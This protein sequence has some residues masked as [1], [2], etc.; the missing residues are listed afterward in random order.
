MTI[1]LS[2]KF[3]FPK[4]QL[5]LLTDTVI[6]DIDK[7][8]K[9]IGADS[10]NGFAI[11]SGNQQIGFASDI[12][13]KI[14]RERTARQPKNKEFLPESDK[15]LQSEI[16]KFAAD[17]AEK[18]YTEDFVI[19]S[20]LSGA[21][22]TFIKSN[23]SKIHHALSVEVQYIDRDKAIKVLEPKYSYIKT[24]PTYTNPRPSIFVRPLSIWDYFEVIKLLDVE[25]LRRL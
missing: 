8:T 18:Y 10:H 19:I 2:R 16:N 14:V 25:E 1:A 24:K 6:S 5:P 17:N 4:S 21:R 12:R 7:L 20:R 13:L 15:F 22:F 9:L 3:S 23:V 11:F